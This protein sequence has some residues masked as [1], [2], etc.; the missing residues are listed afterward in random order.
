[1][2]GKPVHTIA[3]HPSITNRLFCTT[4]EGTLVSTDGGSSWKPP[5]PALKGAEVQTMAF[6][7]SNAGI[8]ALATR[9]NGAYF[10][11]DGG[12][13]WN[14]ANYGM[15]EHEISGVTFSPTDQRTAFAWTSTGKA[16]RSSNGGLE[17]TRQTTPWEA[18][19]RIRIVHDQFLP[20]SVIALVDSQKVFYSGSGGDQWIELGVGILKAEPLALAWN[21]TTGTLYAGTEKDGVLRIVLRQSIEKAEK[22]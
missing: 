18:G 21:H 3:A 8:V 7:P 14:E 17:W 15:G 20:S 19:S 10:S 12:L 13:N 22:R 4:S 1:M 2:S 6:H 5:R 11:S 16:F 9:R